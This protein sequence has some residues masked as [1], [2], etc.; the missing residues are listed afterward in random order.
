MLHDIDLDPINPAKILKVKDDC[1]VLDIG[2]TGMFD[3]NGVFPGHA[4]VVDN[5]I[6]LYYTGFQTGVNVPHYNFGVCFSVILNLSTSVLII[7]YL[8]MFR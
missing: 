5:K 8:F 4:S 2:E 7:T 1:P 3:D 6:F